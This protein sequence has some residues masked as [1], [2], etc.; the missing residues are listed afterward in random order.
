MRCDDFGEIIVERRI[1]LDGAEAIAALESSVEGELVDIRHRS[2]PR[3]LNI[4]NLAGGGVVE[5]G[6][7]ETERASTG[8]RWVA[9]AAGGDVAGGGEDD[10]IR[11]FWTEHGGK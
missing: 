7:F 8:G 4:W 11:G 5:A 10:F 1:L 3:P 2:A 6:G 9:Q